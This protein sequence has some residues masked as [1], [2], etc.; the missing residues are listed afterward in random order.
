MFYVYSFSAYDSYF[1][2]INYDSECFHVFQVTPPAFLHHRPQ[3]LGKK[4]MQKCKKKTK[5]Q[6]KKQKINVRFQN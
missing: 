2:L 5:M 1:L 6:K 3:N 4:K